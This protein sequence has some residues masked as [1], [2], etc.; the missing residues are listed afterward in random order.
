MSF[1]HCLRSHFTEYR[2]YNVQTGTET[3]L[4]IVVLQ[5]LLAMEWNEMKCYEMYSMSQ[6]II[7]LH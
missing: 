1:I 2:V 4:D 6:G 5:V 7:R 3:S